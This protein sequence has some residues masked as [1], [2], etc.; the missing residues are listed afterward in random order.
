MSCIVLSMPDSF[1][2]WFIVA[3]LHV[4]LCTVR[5]R[6]EGEDGKFVMHEMVRI[7]WDDVEQKM[8]AMGVRN[9]GYCYYTY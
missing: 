7:F 6:E 2:S 1:Q 8:T 9:N 5:L 3:H 4:W